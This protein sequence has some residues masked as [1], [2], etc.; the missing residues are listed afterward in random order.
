MAELLKN[1]C[2]TCEKSLARTVP[3][4]SASPGTTLKRVRKLSPGRS[5]TTRLALIDVASV[6][7]A[8]WLAGS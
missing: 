8:V 1:F 4:R 5:T 2:F 7:V 3:L 6:Q